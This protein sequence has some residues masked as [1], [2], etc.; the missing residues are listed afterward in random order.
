MSA[1]KITPS[2]PLLHRR[3]RRHGKAEESAWPRP[4]ELMRGPKPEVKENDPIPPG[5]IGKVIWTTRGGSKVVVVVGE[6][7][8]DQ[9]NNRRLQVADPR[10]D[11]IEGGAKREDIAPYSIAKPGKSEPKA[12]DPSDPKYRSYRFE[13]EV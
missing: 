3:G 6:L 8:I 9:D 13:D 2:N 1:E 12:L 5:F 11:L 4:E 7:G 10:G